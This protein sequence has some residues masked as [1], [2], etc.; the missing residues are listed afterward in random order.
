M[1]DSGSPHDPD[2]RSGSR[3]AAGSESGGPPIGAA[4]YGR[5]APGPVRVAWPVEGAHGPVETNS[6]GA[7]RR[8][9]DH[10]GCR[11]LVLRIRLRSTAGARLNDSA[12]RSRARTS[13]AVHSSR[14]EGQGAVPGG[15]RVRHGAPGSWRGHQSCV[16]RSSGVLPRVG[17]GRHSNRS[18]GV[19]P[20]G[21]IAGGE[22]LHAD[23]ILARTAPRTGTGPANP[24]ERSP[25]PRGSGTRDGSHPRGPRHPGCRAARRGDRRH[26]ASANP[27]LGRHPGGRERARRGTTRG[28]RGNHDHGRRG[29]G[30]V[31][32]DASGRL[33]RE[34][35]MPGLR[36]RRGGD[37]L[38]RW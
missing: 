4:I 26:P 37:F 33:D 30:A 8:C 10:C 5:V 2:L 12:P 35:R 28:P 3:S 19:L 27:G 13:G 11:R 36:C 17:A 32:G 9:L 6:V 23:R 21:G 38:Q 29:S 7:R 20:R 31:P 1:G 18:P 22:S 34:G 16:R 24:H 15:N 14:G 25:R